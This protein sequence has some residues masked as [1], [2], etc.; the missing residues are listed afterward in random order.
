MAGLRPLWTDRELARWMSRFED[1]AEK[2]FIEL[3]KYAGEHFVKLARES[4]KY[5]DITGNLRSSIGYVI[6]K[7]GRIFQDDFKKA[8]KG[9]DRQKGVTKAMVLARMIA[10]THNR[11]YVLIGVAGMDY[12][13]YVENLE[14]KD[15]ISSSAVSTERFL[16]DAI[17]RAE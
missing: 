5:N 4:G 12:A 17:K 7:D 10:K 2:K 13:V 11:G 16:R 15:V 8:S 6:A 1:K 3:L 9:T 14:T